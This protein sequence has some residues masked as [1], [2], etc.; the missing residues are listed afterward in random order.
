MLFLVKT[1]SSPTEYC[2]VGHVASGGLGTVP[3]GWEE[4]EHEL[5]P[6]GW[7]FVQRPAPETLG[8]KLNNTFKGLDVTTRAAFYPIK[9]AM[10]QAVVEGDLEAARAILQGLTVSPDLEAIKDTM[11]AEIT[12]TINQN[13]ING[14]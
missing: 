11:I 4:Q 9:A 10:H 2:A 7:V 6:E 14:V 3:E 12:S 5:L 8:D 13:L 1:G